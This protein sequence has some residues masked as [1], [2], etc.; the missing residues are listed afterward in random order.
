MLRKVVEDYLDSIK[1]IQFFLPFSSLLSRKGFYDIHILHSSSEYSKDIIAKNQEQEFPVQYIFQIKAGDIN[2]SK[3]RGEVQ[4][5]LL[6][7][8][9]NNLSHPNFDI[10]L[11]KKIVF[12][13]TGIIKPPAA[14][15]FQ[16]FNNFIK[17][18]YDLG[19]ILSLEKL[20][21]VDDFVKYGLEPFF[22]LHNDPAFVG[23]FFDFYSRIKNSRELD[24]FKIEEYTRRWIG[25]DSS[26][27]VTRLQVLLEAYLFSALLFNNKQ[28]H[29]TF[30]F[31]AALA[32][33]LLKSKIYDQNHQIILRYLNDIASAILVEI[34]EIYGRET[35]LTY[36]PSCAGLL[37]ILRY[38]KLCLTALEMLCSV[39]LLSEESESRL[40]DSIKEIIRKE[41]GWERPLSDNFGISVALIGLCL[42]KSSN[43]ELLRKVINNVTI[44]LCDRYENLGLAQLG[45]SESEEFEQILSEYLEGF[46]HAK[47]NTSFVAGVLLD[48]SHLIGDPLFY[49]S[50]ANELRASSIIL[51]RFHILKDSD[52]FQYDQIQNSFEHD[53]KREYCEAY[54]KGIVIEREGNT[55]STRSPALFL[56][57]VLLRD[58]TF[59]TF[60]QEL[61]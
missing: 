21:L 51:E 32:R 23:G 18:K 48:L 58:R 1:E 50:I 42:I 19:P 38:P 4:P 30:L 39:Y 46:D 24:S 6:E 22:S 56:L 31:I 17:T 53:Y 49:E 10:N 61:L 40:I 14:I 36:A 43:L 11:Q 60:V 44:W 3:Y 7:A 9:V 8:A 33:Y 47:I 29:Q 2:L 45:A 28:Y 55:I 25:A 52:I 13:T 37:G 20:T 59:P 15:A 57:M 26:D 34:R 16:E 41:R 54:S 35:N 12:V 5:Q 27:E